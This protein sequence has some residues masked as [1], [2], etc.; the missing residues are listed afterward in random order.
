MF[1]YPSGD[2]HVGHWY[3]FGPADTLGRYQRMRGHDVLQPLGYDAFGLPAENAAIKNSIPADEWTAQNVANF[4]AQYQRMGGMYD[5]DRTVNTSDPD[6]Y[7]WT[8]WI[9]LKM[10]EKGL[11]YKKEMPVNWCPKDKCVLANEEV[12][13]GACERCGTL[14]EKKNKKQWML[15]I[16][17]YAERL[18]KDLDETTYLEKIKIQQ[19]NWIGLSEG[20]EIDFEIRGENFEKKFTIFTTRADTIFGC[21]Y[22]VLAPEHPCVEEML[23]VSVIK[24]AKEVTEYRE[25]AR[26][27]LDIDRSAEGKARGHQRRCRHR[28]PAA[29]HGAAQALPR[30]LWH[31][32]G[33]RHATGL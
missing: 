11:A 29:H 25:S 31:R 10:Y 26:L 18:D 14:V 13:D 6:Y 3:N 21:T 28:L 17:K 4:R 23:S 8:Q 27:A 2:L 9:F 19:R 1:P 33:R 5:L 15:A 24:N 12:V 7:R 16:T 30:A 20:S 32:G 22:C